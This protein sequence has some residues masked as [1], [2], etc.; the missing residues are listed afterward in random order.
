[1]NRIEV[2]ISEIENSVS[3]D[4]WHGWPV[5]KILDGITEQQAFSKPLPNAHS[6][7]EL[8][9]HIWA[10]TAE[11]TSR[12]KGNPPGDPIAGDWPDAEQYKSEGWEEIKSKLYSS[13]E[14]LILTLKNFPEFKLDEIVGP[15]R[16]PS[17]GT[18][19]SFEATVHGVAQ[20]NAYHSGQIALLKKYFH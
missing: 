16:E 6:I 11:T 5:K 19:F 20:H 3:G 17:L 8:T 14:E 10:W 1:M 13:T 12:L 15:L 2:L 9:L 18:G 7:V 4:P